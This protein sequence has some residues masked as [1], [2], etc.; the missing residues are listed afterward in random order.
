MTHLRIATHFDAPIERVFELG[1]DFMRYPEWNVTYTDVLEVNGPTDQ[2]GTRIHAISRILGRKIDSWGEIVEVERPR[3]LKV[4]GTGAGG[5]RTT[6]TYT[7]TPVA[8][9]TD[10][11]IEAEYELPAGLFGQVVDKLF[12]ERA[13]E[14][15]VRHTLDNF[16]AIV[17]MKTPALV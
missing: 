10:H 6:I 8:T 4:E 5:A 2:V 9:G 17:E 3:L 1:T 15:D 12:V 13:V 16:K 11:V 14:R 7:S